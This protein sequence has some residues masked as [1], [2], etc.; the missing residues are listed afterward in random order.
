MA[1]HSVYV[2]NT[3]YTIYICLNA[4]IIK[5]DQSVGTRDHTWNK[6]HSIHN[7]AHR[8]SHISH[9]FNFLLLKEKKNLYIT[10]F[11][12][13]YFI[14]ALL[15]VVTDITNACNCHHY[16]LGA[17]IKEKSTSRVLSVAV[18]ETEKSRL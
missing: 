13:R 1:W 17:R 11:I 5:K 2:L 4:C 18:F 8:S 9:I 10:L 15:H 16:I 14:T 3:C 7:S 6:F 12:V